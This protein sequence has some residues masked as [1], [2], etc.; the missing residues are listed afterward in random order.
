MMR[1]QGFD[2][3]ALISLGTGSQGINMVLDESIRRTVVNILK[4]YTGFYDL[5]SEAIQ[6]A[7]DATQWKKLRNP[8][9]YQPRIWIDVDI[10]LAF[11]TLLKGLS[12]RGQCGIHKPCC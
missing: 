11:R 10:K 6:N 3:L 12:G 1:I 7:L 5:F 4:S 8:D 9:T 2:P